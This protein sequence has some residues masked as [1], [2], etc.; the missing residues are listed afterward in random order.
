MPYLY[1]PLSD[2]LIIAQI[3]QDLYKDDIECTTGSHG[4]CQFKKPCSQVD[5]KNIKMKIDVS[6]KDNNTK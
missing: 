6:G 2:S 3:L 4:F 1:I 5:K